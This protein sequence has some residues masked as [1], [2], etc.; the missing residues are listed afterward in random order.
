MCGID[1]YNKCGDIPKA[2]DALWKFLANRGD[3]VDRMN[4]QKTSQKMKC[5]FRSSGKCGISEEQC[6]SEKN[7]CCFLCEDKETCCDVCPRYE[8]RL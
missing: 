4:A 3:W 1:Q 6:P 8:E 7:D 5:E 2:C